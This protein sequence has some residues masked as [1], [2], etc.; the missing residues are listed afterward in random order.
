MRIGDHFLDVG[1]V[2]LFCPNRKAT[3][4]AAIEFYKD[5]NIKN[6]KERIAMGIYHIVLT[7]YAY[8]ALGG[9]VTSCK[10]S[11]SRLK[12]LETGLGLI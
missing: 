6:W 5:K 9:N 12:E 11:E 7:N 2:L 10:S 8:A 3:A 4:S 1:R